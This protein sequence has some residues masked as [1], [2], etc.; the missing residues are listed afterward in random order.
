[1]ARSCL[2]AIALAT[3]LDKV[4]IAFAGARTQ[5][6]A[7]PPSPLR[8]RRVELWRGATRCGCGCCCGSDNIFVAA[9][10]ETRVARVPAVSEA[11][12]RGRFSDEWTPQRA[13]FALRTVRR[14]RHRSLRA[15]FTLFQKRRRLI[16]RRRMLSRSESVG[17]VQRQLQHALQDM[18]QALRAGAD[19]RLRLHVRRAHH[20]RR[21]K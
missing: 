15:G 6:Y 20:C 18:L 5:A 16:K 9:A 8:L 21:R 1:M 4:R 3:V 7:L 12:A 19:G 10:Q 11:T 13:A 17:T 14:S 2:F